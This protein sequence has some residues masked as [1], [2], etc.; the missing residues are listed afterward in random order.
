MELDTAVHEQQL[1]FLQ[2]RNAGGKAKQEDL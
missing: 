2:I 1:W